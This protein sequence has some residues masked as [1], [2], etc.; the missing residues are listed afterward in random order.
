MDDRLYLLVILKEEENLMQHLILPGTL[1]ILRE[2][3]KKEDATSII[4][5]RP[6]KSFQRAARRVIFEGFKL[7]QPEYTPINIRTS[8]R[9]QCSLSRNDPS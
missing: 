8:M 5:K 2:K 3:K 6:R 7:E 9:I 1:N 4:I